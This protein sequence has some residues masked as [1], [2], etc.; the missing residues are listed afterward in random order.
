V[1]EKVADARNGGGFVAS[2]RLD[3]KAEGDAVDVGIGLGNNF[4]SVAERGVMKR[5]AFFLELRGL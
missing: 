4:E 1:F 2:T 5:H 3:V